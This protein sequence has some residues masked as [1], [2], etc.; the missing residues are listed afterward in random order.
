[1]EISTLVVSPVCAK[2]T[3]LANVSNVT[4]SSVMKCPFA[5]TFNNNIDNWSFVPLQLNRTNETLPLGDID[6]YLVCLL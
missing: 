6:L 3:S 5:L 1:M 4:V 2:F